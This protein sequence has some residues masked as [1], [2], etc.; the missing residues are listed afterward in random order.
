M[1]QLARTLGIDPADDLAAIHKEIVDGP[2]LPSSEWAAVATTF[3]EGSKRD[4]EQAARLTEALAASDA[5]RP[6]AYL[7]VFLTDKGEPRASIITG[8]LARQYPSLEVRLE[9]EKSRLQA[10]VARR[11]AV[12]CRDRTEAL[13]TLAREV[14]VRYGAEKDRRGLLDY[15]DLIDKAGAMLDRVDSS[16]VHYKLDLGL[17]HVL[18]DEAQDTSEK[19]WRIV[20]ELVAEFAAGAGARGS[21]TRTLFAV[22]DEKQSIFSFQGAAPRQY[23]EMRRHFAAVFSVSEIGW[24]HVRFDHSFRSGPNVL[25]AVDTVFASAAIHRSITSDEAGMPRHLALPD[26]MPGDVEVWPM[27]EPEAKVEIEAWDAPFDAVPESVRGRSSP[28]RSPAPCAAGSP[29]AHASTRRA[30]RSRPATC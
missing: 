10:L 15:D 6:D 12:A 14:I 8:P 19:Q 28:P 9:A 2:H 21:L 23:E 20:R 22:G 26:A 4:K 25:G 17:D 7:D 11:R 16:W 5:S 27:I 24:R 29:T 18:I 13:I 30:A 3:R 1:A